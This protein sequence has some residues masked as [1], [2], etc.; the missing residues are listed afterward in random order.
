MSTTFE[1]LTLWLSS[2]VLRHYDILI[3]LCLQNVHQS[4]KILVI[5]DNGLSS[6]SKLFLAFEIRT[7]VSW[8]FMSI[9]IKEMPKIF[10]KGFRGFFFF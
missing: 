4:R 3:I 5:L 10:F 2:E 6:S 1:S 9:S 8:F 7:K